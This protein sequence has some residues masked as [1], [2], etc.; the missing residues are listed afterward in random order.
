M[1]N[2]QHVHKLLIREAPGR[3]RGH[4]LPYKLPCHHLH[5]LGG[6]CEW[7]CIV[8]CGVVHVRYL[9]REDWGVKKKREWQLGIDAFTKQSSKKKM[10]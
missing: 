8:A 1:T 6:A 7:L 2:L 5:R 9:G 4:E 3:V 10:R